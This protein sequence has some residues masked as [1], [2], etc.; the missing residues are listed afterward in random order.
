MNGSDKG[1]A[2]L[3]TYHHIVEWMNVMEEAG[4]EGE[5]LV[6]VVVGNKSDLK[7]EGFEK[8]EGNFRLLYNKE[9]KRLGKHEHREVSA[10]E[11]TGVGELFQYVLGRVVEKRYQGKKEREREMVLR[12]EKV[13]VKKG[14][15]GV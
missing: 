15:C 9:S 8:E 13:V 6:Q 5:E 11:R 12:R 4:G 7:E 3:T 14:C 2:D 1:D 10:K